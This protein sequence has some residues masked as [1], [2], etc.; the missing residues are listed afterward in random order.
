MVEI[1]TM[2]SLVLYGTIYDK[3]ALNKNIPGTKIKFPN[4]DR[5]SHLSTHA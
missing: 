4:Y 1:A 2:V 3:L 5:S